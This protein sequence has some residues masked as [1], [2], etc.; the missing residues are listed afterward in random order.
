VGIN[1]TKLFLHY[2]IYSSRLASYLYSCKIFTAAPT[3]HFSDWIVR[4]LAR[5][6]ARRT[7]GKARQSAVQKWTAELHRREKMDG[8]VTPP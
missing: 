7:Y 5:W 3:R 6:K 8:G 1:N 2:F 4:G